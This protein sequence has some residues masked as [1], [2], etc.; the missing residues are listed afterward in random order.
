MKSHDSIHLSHCLLYQSSS[1]SLVADAMF[2]ISWFVQK[3]SVWYKTKLQAEDQL[4]QRVA[5]AFSQL[6]VVTQNQV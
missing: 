3:M 6:L 4:R 1:S 2:Y 5:W